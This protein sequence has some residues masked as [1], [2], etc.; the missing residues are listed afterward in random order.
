VPPF[1]P[2]QPPKPAA[3]SAT[4]GKQMRRRSSIRVPS[5]DDGKQHG[6]DESGGSLASVKI[7][8]NC[9]VSRR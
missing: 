5:L 8:G 7:S 3:K 2:A 4:M 6:K 9:S 1:K